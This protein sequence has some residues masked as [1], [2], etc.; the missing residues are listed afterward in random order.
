MLRRIFFLVSIVGVLVI[1]AGCR[2][3]Q[4]KLTSA[5]NGK[6]VSVKAGEKIIVILDGNPSTGYTWEAKDL[7]RAMLQQVGEATFK[8]GNPGLVG[9]GGTL[10]LTFKTLRAGTTA[11]ELIYHRPWETDVKP[12]GTFVVNVT[13]K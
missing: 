8:S 2:Y 3:K 11:L 5:D 1:T 6:T 9:A 7:D 4:A 12:L 13:V 10:T